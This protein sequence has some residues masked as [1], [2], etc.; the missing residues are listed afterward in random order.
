[1]AE[2]YSTEY[3]QKSRHLESQHERQAE[4]ASE[5][6][7]SGP[8]QGI[9]PSAI[10]GHSW[11][12]R[13]N[14]TVRAEALA[15][16][17]R[18]H[19]NRAIQ[20]FLQ[21]V[22][23]TQSEVMPEEDL[24]G[25]IEAQAGNGAQIEAGVRARL[26]GGLGADMS[27]VRIHTDEEADRLAKSV[28]AMAFTTGQDI[29]FRSGTYNPQSLEGLRLLAHEATH[30][31]QQAHGPVEGVPSGGGVTISDP[32]DASEQAAERA[33]DMIVSGGRQPQR[34]GSSSATAQSVPGP[35]ARPVQRFQAPNGDWLMDAGANAGLGIYN[36]IEAIPGIGNALSLATGAGAGVGAIGASIAGEKETAQQFGRLSEYHGMHAIPGIGNMMA[37]KHAAQDF[38]AAGSN[39]AG[40]P[41][42][43]SVQQ[44]DRE[45]APPLEAFLRSLW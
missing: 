16:A 11:G 44:W 4:A 12:R 37:A 26:E 8:A 36:S 42:E 41:G 14:A 35:S 17:Q 25:R 6:V 29:F 31:V 39:L 34:A 27:G 32:S 2:N 9:V 33:A 40:K 1:M 38:G 18:T 30:T 43:N 21:R 28:E 10:M 5:Q 3:E 19:G 13:A 20:R 15:G 22:A 45:T 23:A 7:P 24:A